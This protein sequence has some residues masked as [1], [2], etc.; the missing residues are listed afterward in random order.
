MGALGAGDARD[1]IPVHATDGLLTLQ[2]PREVTL[3]LKCSH[4]YCSNFD[5]KQTVGMGDVE[6]HN[7]FRSLIARP[8]RVIRKMINQLGD[9]DFAYD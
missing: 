5:S 1:F 7:V 2:D 6:L 9:T 4:P 3:L 8:G